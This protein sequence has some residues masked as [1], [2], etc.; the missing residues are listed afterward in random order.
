VA[1]YSGMLF[2][3]RKF[4]YLGLIKEWDTKC[5]ATQ[6]WIIRMRVDDLIRGRDQPF[7]Q[8][9]TTDGHIRYVAEE[10]IRP[11]SRPSVQE[12]QTLI[13]ENETIGRWFDGIEVFPCGRVRFKLSSEAQLIH[14]EDETLGRAALLNGTLDGELDS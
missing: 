2:K 1:Y 7:Y 11:C 14:S 4:T 6:E 8:T 3:H 9:L 13:N 10:N 5:E 12:L